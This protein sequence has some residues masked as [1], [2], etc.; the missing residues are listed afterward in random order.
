M[1][2]P[3]IE[4]STF[5]FSNIPALLRGLPQRSFVFK[6]IRALFAGIMTCFLGDGLSSPLFSDP[7]EGRASPIPTLFRAVIHARLLTRTQR[8]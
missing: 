2:F 4:L 8:R 6:D 7:D 3:G 1:T 5:V